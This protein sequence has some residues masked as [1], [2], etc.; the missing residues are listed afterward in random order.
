MKSCVIGAAAALVLPC[1][2]ADAQ[3]YKSSA[4]ALAV[5]TVV[6]GLNNPWSLAFLPDGR[7]LVTERPGRLRIVAD[8]KL[9][10]PLPGVPKVFASSQGGLH[11]VALDR[12]FAQ[13]QTIY[14]CFADPLRGRR[15]HLDGAGQARRRQAR[16]REGDLPPGGPAVERPA[17][18]LPHR[19]DA[20]QQPVPDVGRSRL[21]SE[22]GAEPRQSHRQ[23]RAHHAGRR[24]AE[25]Q[26][27]RR[28]QATPSRKS[29]PTAT[30][31]C[32]ARRCIP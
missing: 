24:G 31:M 7:M 12:N 11:D 21:L 9:S 28:A 13:N 18:R 3:T 32:R 22:G 20:R 6:S 1:T 4:G 27:V 2:V 10:P 8:G 16:R 30:A 25:R 14:F 17:F 29:G 15:P 23:D 5:E 19:A 26:S